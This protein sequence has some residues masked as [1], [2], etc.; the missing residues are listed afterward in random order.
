MQ[1]KYDSLERGEFCCSLKLIRVETFFH[2]CI[3][4]KLSQFLIKESYKLTLYLPIMTELCHLSL[5]ANNIMAKLTN[6]F[7]QTGLRTLDWK[8]LF[9]WHWWWLP[10][11]LSKCQSPLLK[12]VHLRNTLIWMIK[13]HYYKINLVLF[14]IWRLCYS[15]NDTGILK[16]M[17]LNAL[18]WSQAS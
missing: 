12:T 9:S 17:F 18:N 13:L 8:Q 2:G 1:I 11:R 6:Q 16:N 15:M 10:L 3:C 14:L 4:D 5:T 7:I